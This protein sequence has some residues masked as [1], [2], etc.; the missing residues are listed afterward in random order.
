MV[1]HHLRAHCR[2]MDIIPVASDRPEVPEGD[3]PSLPGTRSTA[4]DLMVAQPIVSG[5]PPPPRGT[6]PDGPDGPDGPTDQ[7]AA[8]TARTARRPDGPDDR[9]GDGSGADNGPP[10]GGAGPRRLRR[11]TTDRML[12]GVCGGI[13][14]HFD[15]DSNVVRIAFVLLTVFVGVGAVVYLAAWLLLPEDGGG[16]SPSA[17]AAGRRWRRSPAPDG[18]EGST[19]EDAIDGTDDQRRRTST[20][21]LGLVII[22]VIVAVFAA[23][24]PWWIGDGWHPGL[25]VGWLVLAVL[26]Y[27][28]LRPRGGRVS[29]GRLVGRILGILAAVVVGVVVLALSVTL[30]AEALTGVPLRGGIGSHDYRPTTPAQ[31]RSTYRTAVGTMTVDLRQVDFPGHPTSVTASVG[32]GRLLVEVP[33]GVSVSLSAH[34][35]MGNVVYGPGGQSAFVGPAGTTATV[36]GPAARPQLILDADVGIGQ[37]QLVRAAPGAPVDIGDSLSSMPSNPSTPRTDARDTDIRDPEALHAEGHDAD[38]HVTDRLRLSDSNHANHANHATAPLAHDPEGQRE[39]PAGPG[40]AQQ[41]GHHRHRPA[42]VDQVVDQQHPAAVERPRSPG[43][44]RR[45]G[46]TSPTAP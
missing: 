27:L 1:L 31:V 39:D 12:A 19:H 17:A 6:G 28:V 16:T 45:A 11:S 13:A 7:T 21:A 18:V 34:S 46:R 20:L 43:P 3:F 40:R 15:V 36:F 9:S 26:A 23:G 14:E 44:G 37:V 30:V 25:G 2:G 24:G 38:R 8:A 32:I 41:P 4:T 22:G 42:G 10:A 29:F 35:G 33:P 5:D